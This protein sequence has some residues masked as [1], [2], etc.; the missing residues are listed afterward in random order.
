[1]TRRHATLKRFSVLILTLITTCGALSQ[2]AT[3]SITHAPGAISISF[4]LPADAF[5]ATNTTSPPSERSFNGISTTYER[6]KPI[7]P[8]MS[9]MLI[10][11][12][13]SGLMLEIDEGD[14]EVSRTGTPPT[15]CD[16]PELAFPPIRDNANRIYPAV[17]AEM[18]DPV[19]VR[20]IRMVKLTVYPVQ[21]DAD[22]A[23]YIIRRHITASIRETDDEPINPVELPARPQTS[24]QFIKYLEAIVANPE[25]IPR[26]DANG[27]PL[28]NGHY[29]VVTHTDALLW[30]LPFIEWRRKAGYR[31]DILRLENNQATAQATVMNLI[32]QAYLAQVDAGEDPFDTIL[33]IGDRSQYNNTGPA[34]S[35]VLQVYA[36]SSTFRGANHAD[37]RY[38]LLEG[39]DAWPDVAISRFFS[40]S[41]NPAALAVGRTLAYEMNPPMQNPAW[42]GRA[43]VYSQHWG[44]QAESA[45]HPSI[46]TNVRWG[47]ENLQRLGFPDIAVYENTQWD[48]DGAFVGPFLRDQLNR[49]VNIMIGR[50]ENY[51]WRQSLQGVNRNTIFPINICVSGHGESAGYNMARVGD[52]NT[53]KGAVANS[54][55]WGAPATASSSYL[56][57]A[58]VKGLLNDGM[59]LGW[60]RNYAIT[61]IEGV[62]SNF[63]V[64]AMNGSV[65]M[66][67][68]VKT[69][70]DFCGDPGI[71][72]WM[73]TP[74]VPNVSFPE[75]IQTNTTLVS[76]TV[77]DPQNNP[78]EGAI[79]SL[80]APGNIPTGSAANYANYHDLLQ[81]NALTDYDGIARFVLSSN[82]LVQNTHVYLTV[83]G[84]DVRPTMTDLVVGSPAAGLEIQSASIVEID[85]NRDG[86]L[87]PGETG[88]IRFT[89]L[90]TSENI[91]V[92]DGSLEAHSFS[93][94]IEV[95]DS[96][97]HLGDVDPR[98]QATPDEI[99]TFRVLP[100]SPDAATE[101]EY[102]PEMR[103][104]LTGGAQTGLQIPISAPLITVT[105]EANLR[106][107][108]EDRTA[109]RIDLTNKGQ[110]D[111]PEFD[112]RLISL[113]PDAFVTK[114]DS[115]YPAIRATQH[116]T[117]SPDSFVVVVGNEAIPGARI[118]FLLLIT[119]QYG[120]DDTL[121]LSIPAGTASAGDPIGPDPYGY[122]CL[123]NTDT[124]WA[125]APEYS[126][127]EIN[128]TLQNADYDGTRINFTGNSPNQI[129]EASG[130]D[131]GFE[132]QFYGELFDTVTVAS[133]GFITPGNQSRIVNFQN[134]PLDKGFGGGAGMIAPLWDDLRIGATSRVFYFRD[135]DE[136]RFI[137]EWYRVTTSAGQNEFTFEVVL[138]D[139]EHHPTLN[140]DQNI[141][142]QY[143]TATVVDNIRQGDMR[144]SEDLAYASVGISS[145]D[146][147]SGLS[148][149]FNNA[150][151]P[152]AAAIRNQRALLFLTSVHSGGGTIRGR[153]TDFASGQA[154]TGVRVVP[155]TGGEALSDGEGRFE[156][157]EVPSNIPI[158]L[159]ALKTGFS[160]STLT[161]NVPRGDTAAVVFELLQPGIDVTDTLRFQL[162]AGSQSNSQISISNP[163]AGPLRFAIH[164][165]DLS[166]PDS[167]WL[168]VTPRSGSVASGAEFPIR[169]RINATS[170]PVGFSSATV[171]ILCNALDSNRQVRLIVNVE[172]NSAP[173][174]DPHR[175][176]SV[177]RL[178]KACPNPFNSTTTVGVELPVSSDVA[179][180]VFDL[181]GRLLESIYNGKLSSGT[182]R[183]LWE[184]L[185]RP[186]GIYFISLQAGGKLYL[187]K[188]VLVK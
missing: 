188:A 5:F 162:E 110:A 20:G 2:S 89:L 159:T 73:K 97:V 139:N 154:L 101:P 163:G 25:D 166:T 142:F 165:S 65:P 36:D 122:I 58:T 67:R 99:V 96:I 69:D 113:S 24:R 21:Y 108:Y 134:W 62:F 145:P 123:D 63:Q 186:A 19:I 187:Q 119:D 183:F 126:W 88:S 45:W 141:L 6:G 79:V 164:L 48:Q 181:S 29:L 31:M 124:R 51:Y 23:S 107:G 109:L 130:I 16:D 38:A 153:V 71:K 43:V 94:F 125:L 74:M 40:G 90:N 152:A 9:R 178:S 100:G 7:L 86:V 91:P 75:T 103:F 78:V 127:I 72:P 169:L 147:S 77:A 81:M 156:L 92:Q 140:G 11:P 175:Q 129:G 34:A 136:H 14:V 57:L 170:L 149:T 49:G 151:I 160:D 155:E 148:Y 182:H 137:V 168:S 177:L 8:M 27:A 76:V 32:R 157:N 144:W 131:L 17:N 116:A 15:I 66:Y 28:Y 143:R 150:Y 3:V 158:R 61:S 37:F 105:D 53:L 185:E 50:A 173:T 41:A 55:C 117:Q 112:A 83:T 68:Q 33:L 13:K 18:S 171:N 161:V 184:A 10:V 64:Q 39:D 102:I 93:P 22:N 114:P 87:N 132:T 111:M 59:T 4:D 120:I 146:G 106:L 179:L 60:A 176:P 174:L 84:D 118:P 12:P 115:H 104:T 138:Y 47:E 82:S 1:M 35:K 172:P 70:Y 56:W 46:Q 52:G 54:L 133:N 42:F 180:S 128:P 121:H 80:Y 44:N 85:G 135:E 30:H 167:S 26:D 98:Q 95:V